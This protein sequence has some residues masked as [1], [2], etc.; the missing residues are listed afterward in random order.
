MIL[1]ATLPSAASFG[2]LATSFRR[3]WELV[4]TLF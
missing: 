2:L 3:Q 4:N 1:G